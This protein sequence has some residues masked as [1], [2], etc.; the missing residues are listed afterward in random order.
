MSTYFNVEMNISEDHLKN[1]Q[2]LGYDRADIVN[3]VKIRAN[4]YFGTK[5][6]DGYDPIWDEEMKAKFGE[7]NAMFMLLADGIFKSMIY[8]LITQVVSYE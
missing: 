2:R 6:P 4:T 1:A 3:A 8:N 5:N 7:S